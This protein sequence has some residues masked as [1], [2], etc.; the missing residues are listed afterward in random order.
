V[1]KALPYLDHS[2]NACPLCQQDL[3]NEFQRNVKSLFDETY[4]QE[5]S[6]VVL[7]REKYIKTADAL[8]LELEA[9][10]YT[11]SAIQSEADF[12]KAKGEL[13]RLLTINRTRL[14]DKEESVSKS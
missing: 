12:I 2:E 6:K 5:V 13:K 3:P 14:A 10:A 7:L 11:S 1:K 9:Q 8:E 4:D